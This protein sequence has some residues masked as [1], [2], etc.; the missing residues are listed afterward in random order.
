MHPAFQTLRDETGDIYMVPGQA[1]QRSS[2]VIRSIETRGTSLNMPYYGP[3][4]PAP[5]V[6]TGS[7]DGLVPADWSDER[8]LVGGS[9]RNLILNGGDTAVCTEWIRLPIIFKPGAVADTWTSGLWTIEK[10]GAAT[11]TLSDAGGVI[12]EMTT[13]TAPFGTF[14]ANASG[15]T[16]YNGAAAWSVTAAAE[17]A[18]LNYP[19]C[20]IFVTEGTFPVN[21]VLASTDGVTW[22]YMDDDLVSV[23][24]DPDGSAEL[25]YDTDVI[26]T[27]AA[28]GSTTEAAGE[29]T[30]TAT[31]ET[32][33][34]SGDPWTAYLT[35]SPVVP[36]SGK[37]FMKLILSGGTLTKL[38]GPYFAGTPPTE[39][40]DL[41][42][43]TIAY[44]DE[45]LTQ[46]HIGMA[47]I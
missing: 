42:I 16:D 1:W 28:G 43:V 38:R 3:P 36:Q 6:L 35:S 2:G 12:A 29:Y 34:N 17:A 39:T 8:L 20:R 45:G 26:A 32:N 10:T 31:G 40:A 19:P 9:G 30:A 14:A 5:T 22:A 13:G 44:S 33:Y 41:K 15:E 4:T 47:S 25:F 46:W 24:V 11:A 37:V 18:T 23:V 27:R 7:K 21:E